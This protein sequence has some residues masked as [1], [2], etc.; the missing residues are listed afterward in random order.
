[1]IKIVVFIMV[2]HMIKLIAHPYWGCLYKSKSK[3]PLRESCLQPLP[4]HDKTKL[5]VYFAFETV[6]STQQEM[7]KQYLFCD[8]TQCHLIIRA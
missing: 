1:M 4:I 6:K 8:D 3:V 5:V 2:N 7:Y